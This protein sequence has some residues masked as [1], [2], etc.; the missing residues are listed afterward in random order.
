MLGRWGKD[1][2]A[3]QARPKLY[4]VSPSFPFPFLSFSFVTGGEGLGGKGEP[5]GPATV[6]GMMWS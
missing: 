1:R 4:F 2:R 6:G 5:W 3:G